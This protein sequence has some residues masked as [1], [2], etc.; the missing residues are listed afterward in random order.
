M[1]RHRLRLAFLAVALCASPVGAQRVRGELYLPD[2]QSRAVGVLVEASDPGGRIVA[3][4]LTGER[5]EFALTL[6]GVGQYSLRALRIGHRPTALG[7]LDVGEG[8][9]P[10]L[11]V[12]LEDRPITLPKLVV[13]EP[14]T[15]RI[16]T[17]SGQL[18]ARLWGEAS[19]ALGALEVARTRP[20]LEATWVVYDR[21][22]DSTGRSVR[23]QSQQQRKGLSSSPFVS[24]PADSLARVGYVTRDA[25]GVVYQAPDAA[26]LLSDSFAAAHCF[27]VEPGGESRASWIGVAFR[28][29]G[30]RA[31][32][33]IAGTFWLDRETAELRLLEYTYTGV[34]SAVA[35]AGAGGRLEFARLSTGHWIV[36]R[37]HIRMPVVTRRLG[38]FLTSGVRTQDREMLT[39]IHV[40]GGEVVS[41]RRG[42][43]VLYSVNARAFEAIVLS[44]D[45]LVRAGSAT[46]ELVGTNYV[47]AVDSTGRVRID[48]VLPGRYV[49]RFTTPQLQALG[50]GARERQV[51][52]SDT[53]RALVDTMKLPTGEEVVSKACG[54]ETSRRGAAMLFGTVVDESAQPTAGARVTVE[55]WSRLVTEPGASGVLSTDRLETTSDAHGRWRVCG[56]PRDHLL[57]I[58]ASSEN[59]FSEPER[60]RIPIATALIM[61]VLV[62]RRSSAP[63]SLR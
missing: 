28:P 40:R 6:P 34:S 17:D 21:V 42:A 33:D 58:R 13:S 27:Q 62:L 46:V 14:R 36:S 41:A 15:C 24:L 9:H 8:E 53:P 59:R 51:E 12:L 61:R 26:V 37:W 31:L 4:T 18:V 10:P 5:G 52:V 16:R 55:W 19:K 22:L 30:A 54:P 3:R 38:G 1:R 63:E 45:S 56:V 32:P 29:A 2:G 39:A 60:F 47:S 49:A 48:A 35:E 7:R 20:L 23:R 50:V 44:G 11:R 25:Q 57:R 43:S